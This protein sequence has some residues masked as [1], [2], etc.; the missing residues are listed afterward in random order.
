L[1]KQKCYKALAEAK[2]A[3]IRS[4]L[5]YLWSAYCSKSL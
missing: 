4:R 2:A 1:Q 5:S 3:D